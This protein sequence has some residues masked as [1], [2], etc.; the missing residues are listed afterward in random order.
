M[1]AFLSFVIDWMSCGDSWRTC[2]RY[3]AC[4]CSDMEAVAQVVRQAQWL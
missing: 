2:G 3:Q 1:I 4:Y